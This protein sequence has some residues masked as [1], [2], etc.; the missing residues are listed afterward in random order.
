VRQLR[1]GLLAA[2]VL[3]FV[4]L[5]LYLF[6]VI[7]QVHHPTDRLFWLH[8]G[9]DNVGYFEQ[10]RGLL[11]ANLQPNK[12]PLGFPLLLLPFMVALQPAYHQDLLEPVSAFW[13]LVMFPLGQLILAQIAQRVTGLRWLALLTVWVWTVLPLALYTALRLLTSAEAAEIGSG[14][15]MWAQ[16]L[17]DGPA[18]LFTLL[19]AW[20]LLRP[21]TSEDR[22]AAVLGF[23]CGFLMLIRLTGVLSVGAVAAVLVMQRRWRALLLTLFVALVIFSPQM[24]YNL[25]FFGSPLTSGYQVLDQLP[26]R[27]LF[28]VSYL[29]D[30]LSHIGLLPTLLVGTVVVALGTLG[31]VYLWRHNR[32]GAVLIALSITSYLALYSIYYYSWIGGFTRF[33]IPVY[34]FFALIVAGMVGTLVVRE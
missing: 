9:G 14:H 33:L 2:V 25:R 21:R 11:T 19:I 20:V 34:P 12:Y 4:I 28:H 18:A 1:W 26:P 23:L 10:A 16:M 13:G 29:T 22:W 27:G 24:L 32:A 17:S 15:L 30:A 5:S 3:H 6:S 7:P 8:Q 31:V